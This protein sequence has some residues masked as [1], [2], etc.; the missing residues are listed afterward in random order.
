M[1]H[2]TLAYHQYIGKDRPGEGHLVVACWLTM[3]NRNCDVIYSDCMTAPKAI[4]LCWQLFLSNL[5]SFFWQFWKNS[6]SFSIQG[7]REQ[8]LSFFITNSF[9]LIR[10]SVIRERIRRNR[11]IS[12]SGCFHSHCCPMLVM[13]PT[14]KWRAIRQLSKVQLFMC[15]VT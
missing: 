11:T 7:Y 6:L 4:I 5:A 1:K 10:K 14:P 15:L 13:F 2:Y 9:H 12:P 8:K 3:L